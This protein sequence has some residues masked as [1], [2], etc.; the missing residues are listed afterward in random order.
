MQQFLVEE[1]WNMHFLLHLG[2][3]LVVGAPKVGRPKV[4]AHR[5]EGGPLGGP[6]T[7]V[8]NMPEGEDQWITPL[9]AYIAT[10]GEGEEGINREARG[11]PPLQYLIAGGARGAAAKEEE[12]IIKS[13]SSSSM[14]PSAIR[15]PLLQLL[16]LQQQQSL[17]QQQGEGELLLL[18]LLLQQPTGEGTSGGGP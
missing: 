12:G 10:A 16:Q 17:Q 5:K 1:K 6:H 2:V 9:T 3:Y 11:G 14:M 8:R 13:S 15:L 4:G 18:S 7:L